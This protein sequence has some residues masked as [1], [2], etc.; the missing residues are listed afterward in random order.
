MATRA[1]PRCAVS[2]GGRLDI[3]VIRRVNSTASVW[4]SHHTRT[5]MTEHGIDHDLAKEPLGDS[6]H[7]VQKNV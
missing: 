1:G 5:C 4:R 7:D 2:R 3:S 6:C